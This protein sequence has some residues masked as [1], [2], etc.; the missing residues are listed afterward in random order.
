[1][2]N[3]KKSPYLQGMLAGFGA[4]SLS[5]VFFFILFRIRGISEVVSNVMGILSPFVYGGVIA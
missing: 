4:I 2:K 1:M 3:L 5:V